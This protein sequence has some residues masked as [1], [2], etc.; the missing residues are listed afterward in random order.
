MCVLSRERGVRYF[1]KSAV[2]I[3]LL[4]AGLKLIAVFADTSVNM[5]RPDVVFYF[6]PM[7]QLLSIV[8]FCECFCCVV[9]LSKK[10]KEEGK[11]ACI[12]CLASAFVAYRL[13]HYRAVGI[14]TCRC[15]GDV[16]FILSPL[17]TLILSTAL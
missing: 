6:L 8:A 13:V 3:L 4:T 15:F 14:T 5:R 1:L 2:I 11:L 7:Q 10:V 17:V 16:D 9:L 12:A